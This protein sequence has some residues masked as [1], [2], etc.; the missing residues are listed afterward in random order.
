MADFPFDH[1]TDDTSS[2]DSPYP[3]KSANTPQSYAPS[4]QF[5]IHSAKSDCPLPT[6]HETKWMYFDD[7]SKDGYFPNTRSSPVDVPTYFQPRWND[8]SNPSSLRSVNS[9]TFASSN[10]HH[11]EL[12][13]ITEYEPW[14][15]TQPANRQS[16]AEKPTRFHPPTLSSRQQETP[17]SPSLK[18]EHVSHQRWPL[19]R[20][21]SGSGRPL[22]HPASLQTP[23][24]PKRRMS[25]AG[26][27]E[28]SPSTS[29][30]DPCIPVEQVRMIEPREKAAAKI[31][32]SITER[33]YR[34][35][36][37][38]KI[39]QLDQTLSSTRNPKDQAQNFDGQDERYVE[40]PVKA[41]KADV[42]NA[43]M[44]YVKQ[45]E[46]DGEA[47]TKEIEF[48]R[49][50]VAAL[51]KLVNCG[52]CALLKQFAGQQMNHPTDF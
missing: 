11:K 4:P 48:L 17:P 7:M 2:P 49:L 26:T 37:N 6:S 51:E 44:R 42:L 1:S 22:S 24:H 25:A 50:R 27:P 47:R 35:N 3:A 8:A 52:D 21:N 13:K 43:A 38:S 20:A 23:V 31:S 18:Q 29:I 9:D 39:T 15:I 40:T 45:A 5:E 41:R 16:D 19:A 34:E 33:R 46:H 12:A 28:T 10:C 36:L 32:H 30:I 14:S